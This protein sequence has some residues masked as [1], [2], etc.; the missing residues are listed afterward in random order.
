MCA[1]LHLYAVESGKY[2]AYRGVR[3][4]GAGCGRRSGSH[5]LPAGVPQKEIRK[6]A[7]AEKAKRR[8][9]LLPD[10][11]TSVCFQRQPAFFSDVRQTV[12]IS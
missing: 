5:R 1:G 11:C 3:N 7:L 9:A 12:I 6:A 4:M 10:V 8:P 2:G